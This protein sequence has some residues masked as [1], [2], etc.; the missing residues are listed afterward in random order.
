MRN[1]PTLEYFERR[2]VE[3]GC[4]ARRR[5]E[6]VRELSDHYEDLKANAVAEGL[7]DGE[8]EARAAE[9]LGNPVALAE[10]IVAGMR[11]A[12]WWGRHP[13]IGLCLVPPFLFAG[14]WCGC[15]AV[16]AGFCWLLGCLFGPNYALDQHVVGLLGSDEGAFESFV[17]PL[18]RALCFATVA[19]MTA[20]FCWLAR[21]SAL[22]LKWTLFACGACLA[23]GL[24]V[25]SYIRP[26]VITIGFGI[27][28]SFSPCWMCAIIPL[29]AAG[30]MV[31]RQR[32]LENVF[33]PIPPELKDPQ[34]IE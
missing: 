2:L 21:R 31:F 23:T 17:T 20:G 16:L 13:V 1:S 27:S 34:T 28:T 24:F 18:N 5:R 12:S 3:L 25:C 7:P 11:E 30:A 6:K 10:S 29:A 19:V 32:K 26:P 15:A 8:A 33:A 14:V 22:G 4:P 9:A